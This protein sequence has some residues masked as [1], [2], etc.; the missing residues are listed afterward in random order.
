MG[1]TLQKEDASKH[2]SL[3]AFRSWQS[4]SERTE[5]DIPECQVFHIKN[6]PEGALTLP[7]QARARRTNGDVKTF[8]DSP[9]PFCSCMLNRL[10]GALFDGQSWL[11]CTSPVAHAAEEELKDFY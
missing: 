6:K 2:A 5:S 10:G 8:R 11:G 1:G 9:S 7:A 3:S 4:H